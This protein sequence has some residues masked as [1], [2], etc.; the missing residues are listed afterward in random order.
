M[1][2][3]L[4]SVQAL[5]QKEFGRSDRAD[6]NNKDIYNLST[7]ELMTAKPISSSDLPPKGR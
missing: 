2:T 6:N 4:R 7:N 1:D 3:L 5:R